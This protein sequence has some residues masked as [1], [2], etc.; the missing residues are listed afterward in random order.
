MPHKFTIAFYLSLVITFSAVTVAN[1]G[2]INIQPPAENI[3]EFF[4]A[5]SSQTMYLVEDFYDV[6][7]VFVD[8]LVTIRG[9]DALRRYYTGMYDGVEAIR[10]DFTGEVQQGKEHVV[11]W[12]MILKTKKMNKGKPIAVHGN[13][14][15]RF[16]GTEGKAVYHR[17][18]FDVGAMVYEHVPVAGPLTR[19]IKKKLQKHAEPKGR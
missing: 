8:P 10:F 19:Y 3:E 9:R 14:H 18:Y 6:D 4:N 2:R 15:I 11:F 7:A 12:T 1:A 16:G 13:S 17:D 5:L